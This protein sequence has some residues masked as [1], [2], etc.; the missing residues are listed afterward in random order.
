MKQ[1]AAKGDREIATDESKS[2]VV[3]SANQRLV[4][5]ANNDFPTVI[6]FANP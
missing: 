3:R 1:R 6:G 2:V 5:G 4:R